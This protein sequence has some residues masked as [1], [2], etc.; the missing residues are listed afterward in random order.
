M[1]FIASSLARAS[2]SASPGSCAWRT[3][4]PPDCRRADEVAH[5]PLRQI[6]LRDLEA[7]L[8]RG[9]SRAADPARLPSAR[10][11]Q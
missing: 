6:Q 3:S 4:N 1:I 9:E 10:R 2:R 7:I 8:G 5:P 11:M